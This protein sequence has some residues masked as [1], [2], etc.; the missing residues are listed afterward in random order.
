MGAARANGTRPDRVDQ[1]KV[2]RR[3]FLKDGL[4]VTG[5]M[6]VSGLSAVGEGVARTESQGQA[7]GGLDLSKARVVV[8][9]ALS[10]RERK[11]AQ[12][13]VEEVER[14]TQLRWTVVEDLIAQKSEQVAAVVIGS[15][16]ILRESHAELLGGMVEASRPPTAPEGYR[17]RT[18]GHSHG[19]SVLVEGADERGVLFGVGG[20]LRTLRMSKS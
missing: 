20:L 17:L 7:V 6:G 4:T 15:R 11:T 14:R 3:H 19:F 10:P 13:L 16:R 1:V 9:R 12:V 8:P 5:L 18:S 2:N